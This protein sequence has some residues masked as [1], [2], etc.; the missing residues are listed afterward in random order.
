M[1]TTT[2]RP[3][4]EWQIEPRSPT[5]AARVRELWAHR[6]LFRYF[7]VRAMQRLY[8][9]TV[10]GKVWLVLRSPI[11]AV[12]QA[13]I[14]G[15]V[16]GIQAPGGLPYFLFLFTGTCIWQL[17]ANGLMWATR[18]FQMNRAFL[19]K[20]YFPRLIL[21][22]ATMAIAFVYFAIMI[23]MLALT[24]AYY[25]VFEGKA[26]LAPA[27]QFWWA[28]LAFVNAVGL[29]LGVGLFTSVLNAEYRDVRF[30]LRYVLEFWALLTP[31]IYPVTAVPEKWRW[32]VYLNPMTSVVQAFKWGVL[33][34]EPV[35]PLSVLGGTVMV[36]VVMLIGL[37]YFGKAEGRAVDRI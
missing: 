29:A 20:L 11:P 28:G 2:A 19:G 34:V 27:G 1:S 8:Q 33:G 4:A 37:L 23:V 30:T 13:M 26:Y 12:L 10:L 25:Y 7:A 16:L 14:F 31:I 17:F 15:G 35:S 22:A 6:R 5:I 21:P 24:F 18:S 36:I 9:G 32:L 3:V